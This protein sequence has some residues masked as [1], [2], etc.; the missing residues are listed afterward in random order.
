M[1]GLERLLRNLY[2]STPQIDLDL[3]LARVRV[4]KPVAFDF[5]ALVDGLKRANVGYGAAALTADVDIKEGRAV[6]RTGQSLPLEG[7]ASPGRRTFD[8]L[9]GRTSPRLRARP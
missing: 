1:P 2:G 7:P 5:P 3:Q 9:D 6:L 8:V 4:M